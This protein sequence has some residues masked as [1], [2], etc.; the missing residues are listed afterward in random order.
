MGEPD[1][2]ENWVLFWGVEPCSV[3]LQFKFLL[4]GG[5]VF[6]PCCL[7]WVKTMVELMKILVTFSKRSHACTAT[8]SVSD[9]A[10]GH[11]WPMPPSVTL[12]HSQSSLGQSLVGSLHLSPGSFCAQDFV[13]PSKSLFLKSCVSSEGSV[14]GLMVPP[15]RGLM[16]HPCLLWPEPLPLWQTTDDP[17]HCR[18]HSNT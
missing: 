10:A 12:G 4:M 17:Y 9:P 8:L 14:L 18:R 16:P 5:A 13:V 11:H 6:P 1:W 2:G 7:T 15:P 3:N